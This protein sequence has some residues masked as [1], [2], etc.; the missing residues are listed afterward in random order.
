MRFGRSWKGAATLL[1]PQEVR[2]GHPSVA[3]CWLFWLGDN[4]SWAYNSFGSCQVSCFKVREGDLINQV[5]SNYLTVCTFIHAQLCEGQPLLLQHTPIIKVGGLEV[6]SLTQVP[7]HPCGFRLSLTSLLQLHVP[8]P[9][10]AAHP[11][12]SRLQHQAQLHID[13]EISSFT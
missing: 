2:E 8:L 6:K 9:F 12:A 1:Y 4:D 7:V 5:C 10:S 13:C 3:S 11:L